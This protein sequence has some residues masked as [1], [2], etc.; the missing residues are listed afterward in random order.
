MERHK[1]CNFVPR[2]LSICPETSSSRG[3]WLFSSARHTA[4]QEMGQQCSR[5]DG[6][7]NR[8][9]QRPSYTPNSTPNEAGADIHRP[10]LQNQ[11]QNQHYYPSPPPTY[12][13]APQPPAAQMDL[14]NVPPPQLQ[15]AC[16]SQ[17]DVRGV[18]PPPGALDAE[19]QA[20]LD[21]SALEAAIQESLRTNSYSLGIEGLSPLQ[22]EEQRRLEAAIQESLRQNVS[23][24][25]KDTPPCQPSR[26]AS[27]ATQAAAETSHP[28]R[29][30]PQVASHPASATC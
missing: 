25:S 27:R 17:R 16:E 10:Y 14:K 4:K 8:G 29:S 30:A 18:P 11:G 22:Q 5:Q 28:Q 26:S 7:P 6:T 9:S 24:T 20:A 19:L 23:T 13:G 1:A 12:T 3:A 2:G 21:Q 15:A